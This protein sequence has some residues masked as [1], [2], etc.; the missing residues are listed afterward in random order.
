VA[1]AG[2]PARGGPVRELAMQLADLAGTDPVS[3]YRSLSSAPD[4][5]PM[6]VQHAVRTAAGPVQPSGR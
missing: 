1:A 5:A 2:H 6:L 4:E 3:V